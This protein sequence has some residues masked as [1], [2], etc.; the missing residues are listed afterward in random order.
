MSE[1][2][3]SQLVF[4]FSVF[5]YFDFLFFKILISDFQFSNFCFLTLSNIESM[6]CLI[7]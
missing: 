3:K 5:Q 4:Q 2:Q 7:I 6:K 1:N